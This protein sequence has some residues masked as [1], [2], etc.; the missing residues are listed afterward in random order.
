M[1]K[2]STSG[3][4]RGLITHF[5]SRKRLAA[6]SAKKGINLQI[7]D[8]VIGIIKI[9]TVRKIIHNYHI[10]LAQKT[11]P[12]MRISEAR[13]DLTSKCCEERQKLKKIKLY[14]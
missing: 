4:M 12:G 13:Q 10:D 6:S 9:T 1:S 3:L 8:A 7:R 5:Y 14:K 2:K 11:Y